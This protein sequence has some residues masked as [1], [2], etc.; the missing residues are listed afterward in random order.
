WNINIGNF[1]Y[2]FVRKGIT[3]PS[4]GFSRNLHCWEMGMSWQPTR[5]TYSFYIQVRPGTLDF[6][7]IPYNRNNID[8]RSG[9]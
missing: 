2:D 7:K 8:A 4:V 5:G 3:Y 1:G 6:L 9:F